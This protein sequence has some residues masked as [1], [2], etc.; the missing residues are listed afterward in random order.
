MA[1]MHGAGVDKEYPDHCDVSDYV[2]RNIEYYLMRME[3]NDSVTIERVMKALELT[4]ELSNV[5]KGLGRAQWLAGCA[6]LE[7][8]KTKEAARNAARLIK[9]AIP[10][11][12]EGHGREDMLMA[13]IGEAYIASLHFQNEE[14][15]LAAEW[16]RLAREDLNY[17]P[18]YGAPHKKRLD[19][20][21]AESLKRM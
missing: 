19:D 15:G 3:F 17:G 6:L 20:G 18:F 16:Y 8:V 5:K 13:A 11:L 14:Y 7:M 2:D 9:K 4:R 12:K 10:A 21:L 1:E